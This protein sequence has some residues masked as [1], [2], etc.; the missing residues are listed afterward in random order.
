VQWLGILHLAWIFSNSFSVTKSY[1]PP[2]F[3]LQNVILKSNFQTKIAYDASKQHVFILRG[4]NGFGTIEEKTL[5]DSIRQSNFCKFQSAHFYFNMPFWSQIS[6]QNLCTVPL[7]NMFSYFGGKMILKPLR[8]KHC[9]HVHDSIR[10][11]SFCEFQS[12][13]FHFKLSFSS[14]ISKHKLSMM[15]LSNMFS[16]FGG[17]MI[18]EPLRKKHCKHVHDWIRHYIFCEFRSCHFHLKMSF[19]SQISKQNLCTMPVHNMFSYFGG[20]MIL[21]LLG[22]NTLQ[23]CT[24]LNKALHFLRISILS[25]PLEN[26]ILKSNL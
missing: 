10:H 16:Y 2:P 11:Y 22:K 26:V 7:G 3:L 21:E 6:K 9:K 12:F 25:L 17:K 4:K 20:K 14:Q 13:Y 23:A 19:W 24:W 18:L 5:H 1:P 15:P 8:R